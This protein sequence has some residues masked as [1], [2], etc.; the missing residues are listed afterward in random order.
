MNGEEG[1][2]DQRQRRTRAALHG[3]LE[4]LVARMPYSDIGISL[5]AQEANVGRPTFYRHFADMNDLL[6]DRLA[7]DLAGQRDLAIELAKAGGDAGRHESV[8]AVTKFALDRIVD[9]PQL[10]RPL[11]DGSAG[12]NALTLFRQQ[13]TYLSQ[14][15]PYPTDDA[16]RA[17]P[18]LTVAMLS[19]AIGG[20]LLR[21]IEDGLKPEPAQAARLLIALVLPPAG[22]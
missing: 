7:E 10:Y 2:L 17:H 16:R 1:D 14:R 19:G 11:L 4:R 20:F 3:A 12:A 18:A 9:K 6:I 8:F 15:L 5:L 21:W 22:R 13:M